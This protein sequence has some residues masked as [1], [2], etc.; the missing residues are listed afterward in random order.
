MAALSE[1]AGS[2]DRRR[3]LEE[4]RDLLA[5]SLEAVDEKY[6]APLAKQLRET[7]A[8]LESLPVKGGS[9]VDELSQRRKRRKAGASDSAAEG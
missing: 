8:E 7:I 3:A 1:A 4:L 6:R 2:G 5:E 9:K